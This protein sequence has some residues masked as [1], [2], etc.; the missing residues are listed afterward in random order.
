MGLITVIMRWGSF[1]ASPSFFSSGRMLP[2]GRILAGRAVGASPVKR[3]RRW[4]VILCSLSLG[5]RWGTETQHCI[6]RH[7]Q[8]PGTPF[9]VGTGLCLA[10]ATVS[11]RSQVAYIGWMLA[12]FPSRGGQIARLFQ[13]Q[14][15]SRRHC[16]G[17]A[18]SPM[19]NRSLPLGLGG[20]EFPESR[21]GSHVRSE[22][23]RHY[24]HRFRLPFRDGRK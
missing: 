10:R 2:M 3:Y 18:V 24:S 22:C 12:K 1:R 6:R 9:A 7:R 14:R 11:R 20:L 8:L 19:V 4:S 15:T 5:G 23:E 17:T 13:S 16:F 21:S